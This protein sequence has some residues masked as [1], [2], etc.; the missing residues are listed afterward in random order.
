[1]DE[2]VKLKA[3]ILAVILVITGYSSNLSELLALS[4]GDMASIQLNQYAYAAWQ[5]PLAQ[6]DIYLYSFF[7]RSDSVIVIELYGMKEKAD[8]AQKAIENFR[9]L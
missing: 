3:K 6:F 7:D 8:D 9:L 5:Y 4:K 2:M 1:M